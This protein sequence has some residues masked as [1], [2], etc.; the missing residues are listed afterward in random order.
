MLHSLGRQGSM[1]RYFAVSLFLV[2]LAFFCCPSSA[3]PANVPQTRIHVYFGQY[4]TDNMGDTL[5]IL[6]A[7]Y[8]KNYL[9]AAA[10]SRDFLELGYGIQL[11]IEFG[12]AVRFGENWT[13][14]LW[15]GVVIRPKG[16]TSREGI[17]IAPAFTIGLSAIS[18]SMGEEIK[19]EIG[20]GG[21]ASFLFYLGPE[22]AFTFPGLR[23]WELVYRLHHRSGAG[24]ALGGLYEGYNA[25]TLGLRYRF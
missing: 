19:R 13:G 16:F 2:V 22:I 11:G 5:N 12:V 24:G 1:A 3:D 14:E 4:T 25:N 9:L 7:D 21:N 20:R 8:E 15:G 17:T 10:H 6:K 23:R 18:K